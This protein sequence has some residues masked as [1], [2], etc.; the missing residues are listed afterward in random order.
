[1]IQLEDEFGLEHVGSALLDELATGLYQP[2]EVLREYIQNAVD[3]HRE[4]REEMGTESEDPIRI[5]LRGDRITVSDS[6]IGMSESEI[7]MVKAIAVSPK[8]RKDFTLTGHKGVGIWAGMGWFDELELYTSKAGTDKG[9][10][11]KINFS[12]VKEAISDSV[13]IGEAL[14]SNYSIFEYDDDR[15]AHYTDVN[16]I[17]PKNSASIFQDEHEISSFVREVVPCQIDPGFVFHDEVV[18]FYRDN[19]IDTFKIEVNSSPVYKRF[20]SSVEGYSVDAIRVN[21]DIVAK[22]WRCISKTSKRMDIDDKH[23]VGFRLIEKGFALGGGNPYSQKELQGQDPIKL[24]PNYLDWYIGEV[25]II[26]DELKPNLQRDA[27]EGTE[28]ARQFVN[29]L[30]SWYVDTEFD[31]RTKSEVRKL[32][33]INDQVE[34][35]IGRLEKGEATSEEPEIVADLIDRLIKDLRDVEE[36]RIKNRARKKVSYKAAAS[37]DAATRRTRTRL[38]RRLEELQIK[39]LAPEE[40]QVERHPDQSGDSAD[41]SDSQNDVEAPAE[42]GANNELPSANSEGQESTETGVPDDDPGSTILV[43]YE[44]RGNGESKSIRFESLIAL[45]EEAVEREYGGPNSKVRKVIERLV[46]KVSELVSDA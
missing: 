14:N 32:A 37:R 40:D 46:S 42:E 28:F 33:S 30:R 18:G 24:S 16:L 6:G 3:A 17:N 31:A 8:G 26:H 4:W 12:G 10:L 44:L 21:D 20:P 36:L 9:Y 45:V 35:E 29:Q 41:V 13:N 1:M 15:D 11:L 34:S 23:S 27:L 25:H 43:N 7:R 5:E 22:Y 2:P 38:L 19:E 39:L